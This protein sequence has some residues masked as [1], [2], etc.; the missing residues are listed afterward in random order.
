M[1]PSYHLLIA[2]YF[3]TQDVILYIESKSCPTFLFYSFFRCFNLSQRNYFIFFCLG[4][5]RKNVASVLS[6]KTKKDLNAPGLLSHRERCKATEQ[7]VVYPAVAAEKRSG[8]PLNW[9]SDRRRDLGCG[10][11][12]S[13]RH[14]HP[15][16]S[17]EVYSCLS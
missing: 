2:F 4:K 9:C 17:R 6:S 10:T 14:R 16:Y 12:C 5:G 7:K 11:C 1:R 3:N 13:Q 15:G 8:S